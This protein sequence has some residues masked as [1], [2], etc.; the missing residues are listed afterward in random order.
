M[1]KRFIVYLI[2][3][4]LVLAVFFPSLVKLQELQEQNRI[5]EDRIEVLTKYNRQLREELNRLEN[6]PTYIEK[7][8]RDKLGMVKKGELLYRV[9]EE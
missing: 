9:P 1:N 8:A 6:D 5:L 3:A 4:V 2:A 7:I